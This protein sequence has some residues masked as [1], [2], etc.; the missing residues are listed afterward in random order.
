LAKGSDRERLFFAGCT[1]RLPRLKRPALVAFGGL[2]VY[3]RQ[4]GR[5]S[6]V[7]LVMSVPA[8]SDG[9]TRDW[10]TTALREAGAVYNARVTSVQSGLLAIW[11]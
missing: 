11:G 5:C 9:I 2:L 10:L 6:D 8:D 4:G 7:R 1:Q 3:R